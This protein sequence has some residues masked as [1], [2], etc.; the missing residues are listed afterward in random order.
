MPAP[1]ALSPLAWTALRIGAAAAVA[2]Y[3]SRRSASQPK[4]AEHAHVLDG[5][6]E[7]LAA[8]PHSAE[9]ESGLHGAGRFKRTF[10]FGAGG[11][12]FEIDAAALGRLRVRRV[13]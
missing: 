9:A 3:A 5:L 13:D 8:H 6:P 12:G 1:L 2:I 10:R 11:P 4:D 7:G